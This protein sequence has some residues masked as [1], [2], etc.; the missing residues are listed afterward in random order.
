MP[1]FMDRHELTGATAEDIARAHTADVAIQAQ[2]GVNYLTYW[3][4]YQRQHAFCLA[5][6]PDR[7]SVDTVHRKAHGK[8]ATRIIDVDE[9]VVARFMGG[10]SAHAMGEA[11]EDPGF[12]AI[13]FTDLVGSTELTQRLGDTAAMQVLRRHDSI[14]RET[15]ATTGGSE[16]KH[17]GDGIMASFKTADTALEAAISIQRAFLSAQQS[18]DLQVSVR[19]GIA[20]G[21]PVAEGADL[22]GSVVQLAARLTARARPGRILVSSDVREL[23]V[24]GGVG[25]GNTTSVRLKGFPEAVRVVE[26]RWATQ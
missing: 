16:V 20:A 25:F 6:G 17:T 11:F 19:I 22:F 3:F 7:E 10:L 26:V 14:V 1:F 9:A 23:S 2:Y 12:R 21:E 5:Q 4:D 15:I 18:G 8:L 13:L 24:D